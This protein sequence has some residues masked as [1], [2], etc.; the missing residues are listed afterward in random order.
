[1]IANNL[2]AIQIVLGTIF[3]ANS[4]PVENKSFPG[5]VPI[6]TYSF[7]ENN[8]RDYDGF[9][10]E[11]IRRK[12]IDF[13]NYNK[14]SIDRESGSDESRQ[15]L[16][17]DLKRDQIAIYSPI[18]KIDAPH[19]YLVTGK[20]KTRGLFNSAAVISISFLWLFR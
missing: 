17:F 11:W 14:I 19:S 1:M 13:P 9:P 16:R 8:D 20:I 10:D 5:A 15:S 7:E 6:A 12:G 3:F 4:K 18:K 2:I